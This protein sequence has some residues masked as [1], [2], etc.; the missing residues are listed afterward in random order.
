M[1]QVTKKVKQSHLGM[2]AWAPVAQPVDR[3]SLKRPRSEADFRHWFESR[4]KNVVFLQPKKNQLSGQ[5]RKNRF[6]W[7]N[8]G[9]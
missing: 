7:F 6:N 4:S 8:Y 5:V 3:A 1:I 2:S 9:C